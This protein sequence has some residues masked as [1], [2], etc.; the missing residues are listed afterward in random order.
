MTPNKMTITVVSAIISGSSCGQNG[1]AGVGIT[2]VTTN[3]TG[4]NTVSIL[5]QP[6]GKDI[7]LMGTTWNNG[8][9]V[10]FNFNAPLNLNCKDTLKICVKI[11]F[12]DKNCKACSIYKC[13]TVVRKWKKIIDTAVPVGTNINRN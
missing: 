11:I 4:L 10:G 5:N 2:A 8:S 1:P 12:Y 9:N 6:Y 3:T 13:F 7:S